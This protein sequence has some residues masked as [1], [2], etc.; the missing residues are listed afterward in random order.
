M[1]EA[2]A[3]E[4][5]ACLSPT[6]AGHSCFTQE[7]SEAAKRDFRA[8]SLLLIGTPHILIGKVG[9]DEVGI[10]IRGATPETAADDYRNMLTSL[11]ESDEP[12]ANLVADV[13]EQWKDRQL[14]RS[15]RIP[16]TGTF[17]D[18][19]AEE[20]KKMLERMGAKLVDMTPKPKKN[21]K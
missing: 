6:G 15:A 17:A 2:T 21:K 20:M 12:F 4:N 1:K 5:P 8:A 16:R 10:S 19:A 3:T 13:V 9:E 11:F 18:L 7:S 14:R